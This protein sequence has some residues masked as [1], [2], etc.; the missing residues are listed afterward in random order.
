MPRAPRKIALSQVNLNALRRPPQAPV[1][2]VA[3]VA[4]PP[5][6]P[7][8]TNPNTILSFMRQQNS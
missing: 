1:S 8:E 5:L 6:P 4:G 2:R 7:P 3:H